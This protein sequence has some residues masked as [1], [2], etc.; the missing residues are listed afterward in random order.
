MDLR[1]HLSG[2]GV[3][4]VYDD[5]SWRR[6]MFGLEGLRFLHAFEEAQDGLVR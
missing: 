1:Q 4:G 5:T 6:S 3:K 2:L